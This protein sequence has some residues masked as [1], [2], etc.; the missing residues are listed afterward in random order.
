MRYL[1]R[2]VAALLLAA[3]ASFAAA[4]ATALTL[5]IAPGVAVE[6][7]VPAGLCALDPKAHAADR[8]AFGQMEALQ[9]GVNKV[10]AFLAECSALEAARS[11]TNA[12]L[13]RWVI[14]LAQMQQ[15]QLRT[16]DGMT[17]KAYLDA[18][19]PHVGRAQG[20]TRLE[21]DVRERLRQVF[22]DGSTSV[23]VQ[24]MLGELASEEHSFYTGMVMLNR[25]SGREM[26]VAA[27]IGYTTIKNYPVTVNLYKPFS[28]PSDFETL[29]G[30]ARMMVADLVSRNDPAQT[31]SSGE[32][33]YFDWGKIAWNALIAG[34][35]AMLVVGVVVLWRRLRG[36]KRP[37][38]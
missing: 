3:A 27:V 19:R 10:L 24:R 22:K 31:S 21:G 33:S 2:G 32:R 38:G 17:R 23:G 11:G 16:V 14:V 36:P 25:V 6:M 30:E 7:A 20:D 28:Q 18:L 15:G 26:P 29:V 9:A 34:L 12:A 35:V 13:Q 5:E 8:Q 4:P 37:L 1:A